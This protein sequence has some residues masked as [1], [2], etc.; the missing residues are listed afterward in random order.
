MPLVAMQSQL[1]KDNPRPL[2]TRFLELQNTI[3]RLQ[4][5]IDIKDLTEARRLEMM[6]NFQSY[7][8]EISKAEKLHHEN[9]DKSIKEAVWIVNMLTH[10]LKAADTE[11]NQ[12]SYIQ[13]QAKL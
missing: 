9:S 11:I 3:A 5:D 12:Y 13:P 4:I 1:D 10:H 6:N 7:K 8:S 2:A